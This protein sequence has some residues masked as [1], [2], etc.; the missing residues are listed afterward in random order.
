MVIIFGASFLAYNLQAYSSDPLSVFGESTEINRDYLIAKTIRDLQLN[1]P[2][3]VRY[4]S[5]LRGIVAGLWGDF[6]MGLTRFD[7]SLI[8]I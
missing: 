6:D 4:F 2:P 5:W 7:L 3:P 1:V 8:H